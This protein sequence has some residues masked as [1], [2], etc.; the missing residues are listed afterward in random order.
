MYEVNDHFQQ[1]LLL[2][3]ITLLVKACHRFYRFLS[4]KT[5][6]IFLFAKSHECQRASKTQI[7][8]A[9]RRKTKSSIIALCWGVRAWSLVHDRPAESS[10]L[11]IHIHQSRGNDN[12]KKFQKRKKMNK[13][14]G[15]KRRRRHLCQILKL[16]K[17]YDITFSLSLI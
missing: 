4:N 15:R 16:W 17:I 6:L 12:G 11:C 2:R 13:K 5:R 10:S 7:I 14:W 3:S 9:W 8:L 1:H